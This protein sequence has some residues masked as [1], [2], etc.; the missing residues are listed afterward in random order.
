MDSG[1]AS[2][3]GCAH[4][5]HREIREAGCARRLFLGWPLVNIYNRRRFFQ[6]VKDFIFAG[7]LPS[8]RAEKCRFLAVH[9]RLLAKGGRSRWFLDAAIGGALVIKRYVRFWPTASFRC[10]AE[11]GRYRGKYEN[12]G[13][14]FM[15]SSVAGKLQVALALLAVV[16]R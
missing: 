8:A 15:Q 14:L 11:F 12:G 9:A 10:G 1:A 7:P 13:L 2:R 16:G 6:E 3:S 5:D 4:E